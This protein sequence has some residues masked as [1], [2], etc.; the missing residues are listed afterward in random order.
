MKKTRFVHQLSAE[1]FGDV[2]KKQWL[3]DMEYAEYRE[4]LPPECYTVFRTNKK[5][6][7]DV[8]LLTIE[9]CTYEG[10]GLEDVKR[11]EAN[12]LVVVSVHDL[13]K[14]RHAFIDVLEPWVD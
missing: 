5:T 12:A 9:V 8:P 13:K 6:S 3:S 2:P 14:G 11:G 4:R 10:M 1:G 7:F